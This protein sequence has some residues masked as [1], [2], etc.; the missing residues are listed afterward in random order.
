MIPVRIA[1]PLG[2]I[3]NE[4]IS[5]AMKYAYSDMADNTIEITIAD[6]QGHLIITVQD[7]GKG[8]DVATTPKGFGLELVGNLVDQIGGSFNM[9]QDR[10]TRCVLEFEI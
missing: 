4:L 10:G 9:E 6:K 7:N 8:F 5:N 3:I 2:I 1:S